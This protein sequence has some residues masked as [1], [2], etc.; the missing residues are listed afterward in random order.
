MA[1][2][3][4]GVCAVF[5]GAELPH[6]PLVDT[7][8]IAGLAKTPQPALAVD[9]V[10]FVGESIALVLAESRYEAEDGVEQ[11]VVDYDELP[12]VV[13]AVEALAPGAPVLHPKLG[14][15]LLYRQRTEYGAP[16]AAF[17]QAAYKVP[18]HLEHNRYGACPLEARACAASFDAG[19]GQLTVWSS[20]QGPH[21]LRRRLAE[22]IGLSES[23]IRV[24]VPDVGGAFGQ[25][26]PAH[27][28]EVAVALA[29]RVIGRPVIW[30]EDRY[31][32]LVAAPQAKEQLLDLE[33]ALA[34]DG[35]FLG[36][37]GSIVGNAGAYSYNNAS[38]LI[39]PYLSAVLMPGVYSWLGVDLEVTA[40]VTNKAPVAPYRGVGWTA[41]HAA[42]ELLIEAAARELGL[43]PAELRR[44]NMVASDSFPFRSATG[45]TYDS[46]TFREALDRA[47]E[48]VGYD[49]FRQAQ[50]SERHAGRYRGV[51]ISPYVEP[52]GWG[53]DGSAQASWVLSSHDAIRVTLEPSGEVTVAVGTPSQGQGHTTALAQVAAEVLTVHPRDVRVEA[54]DTRAIPVS[55]PGTRASRTAVVIAGG[56]LLACEE[57]ARRVKAV[58]AALLGAA[59]DDLEL[60]DGDV[61]R[62][63]DVGR[64]ASLREVAEA[65]YYNPAVRA[66]VPQPELSVTHFHD[67]KATYSNGCVVAVV[68]VDPGTGQTRVERVVVVEDCGTIINPLI[69]EGQIRGAVAQG[70]GGALLERLDHDQDGQPLTVSLADYGLPTA[71]EIPAI[72]I[73]HLCSPSPQT[74]AGI[75]GMG[76]GGMIATPA[77]IALAVTDA[78]APFGATV[79]RLPL[80]PDVVAT[81]LSRPAQELMTACTP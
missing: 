79:T 52:T 41:G 3:T 15:N 38:A 25:K 72:E 64:R 61:V 60:V 75:K 12:A 19:S 70:I 1:R 9:C 16:A 71:M 53:T 11:I 40:A 8:P 81:S 45:M 5:T 34:G 42:R 2:A 68:E 49:A 14:T 30:I 74:P 23:H 58:G 32:N 37:R 13:D 65:A 69:V 27:P 21:L 54:N 28:E 17:A 51:G 26:I 10:R 29:A 4:S 59:S 77:A 39:E 47:L 62:R 73:E 57:L 6:R 7:L 24:I 48:R 31:E 43:D 44:R 78:L 35:T 18:V 36:L 80:T 55:V 56:L 22:S 33:L 50:Q 46:G 63:D 67:P 66:T 76:E 20:T